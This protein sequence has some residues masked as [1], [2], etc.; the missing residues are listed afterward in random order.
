VVEMRQT[1]QGKRC[2]GISG[3]GRL[4]RELFNLKRAILKQYHNAFMIRSPT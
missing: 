4:F 1:I 3:N 2:L